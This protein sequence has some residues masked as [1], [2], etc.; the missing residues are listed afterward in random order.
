MS[1]A[2]QGCCTLESLRVTRRREQNARVLC[3]RLTSHRF[4]EID[5]GAGAPS[6][7]WA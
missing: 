4:D 3:G 7:I 1:E 5:A 6:A 2:E